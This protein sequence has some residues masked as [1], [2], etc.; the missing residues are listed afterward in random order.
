MEIERRE[1]T[2]VESEHESGILGPSVTDA[3]LRRIQAEVD[4]E[5]RQREQR[6]KIVANMIVTKQPRGNYFVRNPGL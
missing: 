4:A 5:A 6:E 3:D 1:S 2:P